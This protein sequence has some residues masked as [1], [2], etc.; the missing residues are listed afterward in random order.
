MTRQFTQRSLAMVLMLCLIFVAA[1]SGNNG[2][3]NGGGNSGGNKDAGAEGKTEGEGGEQAEAKPVTLRIMW[4]GSQERHDNTLKVLELYSQKFPHVKF[5]PEYAAVQGYFEKLVTLSAAKNLPDIV[6]MDMAIMEQYVKR[7]QLLDVSDVD[8][9][10]L[11]DSKLLDAIKFDGKLYGIP[12]SLNG[13]GY[14]YNKADIEKYGLTPPSKNWTWDDYFK[15]AEDARQKLPKDRYGIQD[16]SRAWFHFQ[17]YQMANGKGPVFPGDGTVHIDKDLWMKLQQI[18]MKY[19]SEDIVPPADKTVSFKEG[20]PQMDPIASGAVLVTGAT[21]ASAGVVENLMPGK[22]GVVNDPTAAEGGGWSQPTLFWS[23]AENSDNKEEA[24][25]FAKWFLEDPE[26]GKIMKTA[27]GIPLNEEAW[28]AI[29][30]ELL[31][32]Q[33]LG[34]DMLEMGRE[35]GQKFYPL[36]AGAQ[37]FEKIYNSEMEAVMFKKQTIE[38]AFDKIMAAAKDA[39]GKMAEVK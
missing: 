13:G 17:T 18:Y 27:R 24:L 21:V 29:E 5:Q 12:T 16:Q 34:K 15:F 31:P 33:K 20:D 6:H 35:M 8:L 32:G 10:G 26:A 28:K 9:S 23:V 25:K 7:G 3:N 14:I 1:C 36:P 30:P 39:E 2:G 19:R 4:G 37:D 22:I 38:K 11:V